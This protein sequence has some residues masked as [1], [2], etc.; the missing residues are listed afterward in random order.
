MNLKLSRTVDYG[1]RLVLFLGK[2]DHLMSMPKLSKL[3]HIPYNNLIKIV[4]KLTKAGL[5]VTSQGKFGGIKLAVL[6]TELNLLSVVESLDGPIALL[7]CLEQSDSKKE[8]CSFLCSCSLKDVFST[9]QIQMKSY[10]SDVY[11]SDIGMFSDKI[12]KEVI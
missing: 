12:K 3:L 7:H 4:S 2:Q 6:P 9:L 8:A 10:L 5:I 11:V 1:L